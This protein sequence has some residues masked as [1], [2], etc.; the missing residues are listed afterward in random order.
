HLRQ[1]GDLFDNRTSRTAMYPGSKCLRPR[2]EGGRDLEEACL[3]RRPLITSP[4]RPSTRPKGGTM[5][6]RVKN[7][8]SGM[9]DAAPRLPDVLPEDRCLSPRA[10][11]PPYASSTPKALFS[12]MNQQ[13]GQTRRT[14][15][16]RDKKKLRCIWLA[17]D[18]GDQHIVRPPLLDGIHYACIGTSR[19]GQDALAKVKRTDALSVQLEK[20]AR[21]MDAVHTYEQSSKMLKRSEA[22]DVTADELKWLRV[23]YE[24]RCVQLVALCMLGARKSDAN[25]DNTPFLKAEELTARDGLQ[26]CKKHVQR[27]AV[28]Q[29]IANHYKKQ[30]KYQAALQAAEKAVRI[31]EKLP[32]RDR[33]PI[34][35]FLKACLHGLLTDPSNAGLMYTE[36]LQLATAQQPCGAAHEDEQARETFNVLRAAAL[37]NMAIEWANLHMPDQ[38]RDALASA[39]EVGVN[40]LPQTHPVVMRILD[41]YKVMRQSFLFKGSIPGEAKPAASRLAP[42]LSFMNTDDLSLPKPLP[43]T[44]PKNATNQTASGRSPRVSQQ[45]QR[46]AET[47]PAAH[48]HL[49]PQRPPSKPPSETEAIRLRDSPRKRSTK[50]PMSTPEMPTGLIGRPLTAG[51]TRTSYVVAMPEDG[52][53]HALGAKYNHHKGHVIAEARSFVAR[54]KAATRIQKL[55]RSALKRHHARQR[56]IAEASVQIQSLARMHRD[57]KKYRQVLESTRLIQ[58]LWRGSLARLRYANQLRSSIRIQSAWKG[59]HAR[60]ALA[61]KRAKATR[62]QAVMRGFLARKVAA[63]QQASAVVIQSQFRRMMDERALSEAFAAAATINRMIRGVHARRVLL[64]QAAQDRERALLLK[65]EERARVLALQAEECEQSLTLQVEAAMEELLMMVETLAEVMAASAAETQQEAV[66]EDV[67]ISTPTMRD[68]VFGAFQA[69]CA[70]DA[71]LPVHEISDYEDPEFDKHE[72]GNEHERSVEVPGA[73]SPNR[74]QYQLSRSET[75]DQLVNVILSSIVSNNVDAAVS[76]AIDD[77]AQEQ[78]RCTPKAQLS[79]VSSRVNARQAKLGGLNKAQQTQEITAAVVM[80]ADADVAEAEAAEVSAAVEAAVEATVAAAMVAD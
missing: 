11:A 4:L 76:S 49:S 62:M 63:T 47:S 79:V 8:P 80:A 38:C 60:I 64:K 48:H 46:N 5:R 19:F 12:S 67:E 1:A 75:N 7:T 53:A 50:R 20:N 15:D 39:M 51:A 17:P 35:Y 78:L 28:F 16:L 57:R 37:H 59:K 29:N 23:D 68:D 66:Q 24:I 32:V 72:P 77:V 54:K 45:L 42:P 41:T 31:N 70:G 55:W 27:A 43:P 61:L 6:R 34:S 18:E 58:A 26:Y 10:S 71:Q 40:H 33:L 65:A 69:E 74:L 44:S 36:C 13:S 73:A 2:V 30:K 22:H 9:A 3:P 14:L 25:A 52:Y 21:F 56:L